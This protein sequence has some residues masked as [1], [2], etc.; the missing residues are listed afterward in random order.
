MVIMVAYVLFW[1]DSTQQYL[2][3]DLSQED[4]RDPQLA[5]PIGI[6]MLCC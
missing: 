2:E 4:D 3:G 1:H 6:G 5:P